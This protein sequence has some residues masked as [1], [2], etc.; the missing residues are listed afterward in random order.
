MLMRHDCFGYSGIGD[1]A[2][3]WKLLQESSQCVETPTVV[4]SVAQLAQ[5]PLEDSEALKNFFIREQEFLGV[6]HEATGGKG[7]SLR[8]AFQSVDL[9]GPDNE[10]CKFCYKGELQSGNE[11]HK[12]EEK[13]LELP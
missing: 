3:T 5:L 4:N 2:K 9:Q 11:L 6:S 8:D 7:S 13:A 1:G 10:V 12:V